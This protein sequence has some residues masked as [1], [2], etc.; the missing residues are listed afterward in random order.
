IHRPVYG[1]SF[2][3]NAPD[4][5]WFNE[6]PDWLVDPKVTPVEYEARAAALWRK[7]WLARAQCRAHDYA[8]TPSFSYILSH[9]NHRNN[10]DSESD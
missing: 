2:V 9:D 3:A 10:S 7:R 6:T 1:A 8:L 4:V 5:A